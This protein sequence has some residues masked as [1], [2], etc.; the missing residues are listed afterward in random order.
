MKLRRY[1]AED[2]DAAAQL[3]YETVHTVNAADYT[4]EQRE[5]WTSGR[6]FGDL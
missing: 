5:A 6:C 2:R 3:F 1:Q 4:K